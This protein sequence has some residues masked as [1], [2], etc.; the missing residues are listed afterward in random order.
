MMRSAGRFRN[1]T[2]YAVD[3]QHCFTISPRDSCAT[4]CGAL[5]RRIQRASFGV[6]N[7]PTPSSQR[8]LNFLNLCFSKF[9]NPFFTFNIFVAFVQTPHAITR[10]NGAFKSVS[11]WARCIRDERFQPLCLSFRARQSRPASFRL[12]AY[13][14]FV[15]RRCQRLGARHAVAAGFV[16]FCAATLRACRAYISFHAT[17][18][19]L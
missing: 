5:I 2:S 12:A 11:M 7:S 3:F 1:K 13:F 15:T 6:F 9:F 14:Q 19:V 18:F 8:G 4:F 16:A 17:E 10:A